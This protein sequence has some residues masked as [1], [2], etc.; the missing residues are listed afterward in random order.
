MTLEEA[1]FS[2]S[3]VIASGKK[4]SLSAE[5]EAEFGNSTNSFK[6]V[7]NHYRQ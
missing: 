4:S 3:L 1:L 6:L 7:F 2:V 5:K